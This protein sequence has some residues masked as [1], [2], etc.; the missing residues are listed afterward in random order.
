MTNSRKKIE[1]LHKLGALS[2]RSKDKALKEIDVLVREHNE[3]KTSEI[4]EIKQILLTQFNFSY[5]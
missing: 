1:K 3:S 2:D 4:Q 5:V